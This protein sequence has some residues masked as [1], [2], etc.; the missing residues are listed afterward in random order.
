MTKTALRPTKYIDNIQ[1]ARM[2]IPDQNY[3]EK[4]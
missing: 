4:P 3:I 2:V 1:Y